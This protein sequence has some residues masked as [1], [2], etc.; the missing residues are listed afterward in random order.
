MQA[1][2][3]ELALA[4]LVWSQ[5]W[6]KHFLVVYLYCKTIEKMSALKTL[7][8]ERFHQ[9]NTHW[10]KVSSHSFCAV[11]RFFMNEV[12]FHRKTSPIYS[13]LRIPLCGFFASTLE[14]GLNWG[15]WD[16]SILS[17]VVAQIWLDPLWGFWG[18]WE[19]IINYFFDKSTLSCLF[20]PRRGVFG[21]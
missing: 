13:I 20:W 6:N 17:E 1:Y 15:R 2:W 18:C 11:L 7:K 4:F 3:T 14:F 10:L 8:R 9:S 12:T 19:T 5:S 16:V 21:L